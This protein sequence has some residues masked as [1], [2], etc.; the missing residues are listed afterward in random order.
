MN[1]DANGKICGCIH[2]G[3]SQEN[4]YTRTTGIEKKA[5]EAEMQEAFIEFL[6]SPPEELSKKSN[7]TKVAKNWF[8]WPANFEDFKNLSTDKLMS[9]CRLCNVNVKYF[10][11]TK[12]S[13]SF[14]KTRNMLLADLLKFAKKRYNISTKWLNDEATT[15]KTDFINMFKHY[16]QEVNNYIY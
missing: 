5:T 14:T 3:E 6:N 11:T 2:I 13:T 16:A 15:T 12:N 4:F 10:P 8:E 9:G 7:K 1:C